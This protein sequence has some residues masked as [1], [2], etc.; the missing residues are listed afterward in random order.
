MKLK[1]TV[2]SKAKTAKSSSFSFYSELE[3]KALAMGVT[4]L[5]SS[6]K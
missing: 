5:H 2:D 4:L 1:G 6:F 3:S